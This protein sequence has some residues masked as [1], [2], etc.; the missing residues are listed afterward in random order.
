MPGQMLGSG[1]GRRDGS[2]QA[3]VEG[4]RAPGPTVRL[5][6]TLGVGVV[7]L[8]REAGEPADDVV[9]AHGEW[10][11]GV[12]CEAE[13]QMHCPIA[14]TDLDGRL[15]RAEQRGGLRGQREARSSSIRVRD[16]EAKRSRQR[17]RQQRALTRRACGP[18][19]AD[20]RGEGS[21]T[22]WR[23]ERRGQQDHMAMRGGEAAVCPMSG[24][25]MGSS[26]SQTHAAHV[27]LHAGHA[28]LGLERQAAC[29]VHDT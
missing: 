17:E 18:R 29:V 13:H 22:T 28:V 12:L 11:Y 9:I 27:G 5:R 19:W 10:A 24:P 1:S 8:A 3:P 20:A 2:C 6:R 14:H 4:S 21:A 25:C 16:T 7:N 26:R 15:E 23:C